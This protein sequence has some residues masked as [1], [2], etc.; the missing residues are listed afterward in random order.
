MPNAPH[1]IRNQLFQRASHLAPTI[2]ATVFGMPVPSH[3][4]VR[5]ESGD[6][7]T[8]DPTERRADTVVTLR[9]DEGAPLLAV[10]VEVQT[11]R[12]DEKRYTWLAYYATLAERLRCEVVLMAVCPSRSIAKWSAKPQDFGQ[13]GHRFAPLVLGPEQ[14]PPVTDSD[15]VGRMPE[16]AVLSTLAHPEERWI[17]V[18]CTGLD[19][20]DPDQARLYTGY[21]L[22]LLPEAARKYL[23]ATVATETFPYM[24]EFTQ[25]YVDMGKAEGE[26]KGEANAVVVFLEARGITV[27]TWA[28]ERIRA[29][30]NMEQL[31][32][33]TR[34]AATVT[35]VEELFD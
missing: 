20:I 10:I 33:W 24:S 17:D 4:E 34:R 27:P 13:P 2:L 7:T 15:D 21:V 22:A 1:E 16:L 29:C 31:D 19:A 30:T 8:C 6:L 9:D 18:L 32:T 35:S 3:T 11:C 28:Q 23:E 14:L 26:A 12:D 5:L 25:S